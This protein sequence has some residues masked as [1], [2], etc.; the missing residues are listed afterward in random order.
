MIPW[1]NGSFGNSMILETGPA[2]LT[3]SLT[4]TDLTGYQGNT[5][6]MQIL[7]SCAATLK[8]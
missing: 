8:S 2:S 1:F 4:L 6:F 3:L 7:K 5:H